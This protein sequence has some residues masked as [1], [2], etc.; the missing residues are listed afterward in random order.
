MKKQ[1]IDT[2]SLKSQ[3]GF[4]LFMAL[5]ALVAMS[6]T[7]MALMRSVD[8]GNVIAGNVA[9]K[10]TSSQV[11]DVGLES[12]F[13]YLTTTLTVADLSTNQPTGCTTNCNYYAIKQAVDLHDMPSAIA[14]SGVAPVDTS[15]MPSING[16]YTIK[17]VVERLC[18]VATVSDPSTECYLTPLPD[19]CRGVSASSSPICSST[20]GT[21]YRATTFVTGP[22]NTMSYAQSTFIRY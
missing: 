17:Y 2:V 12:A 8:T 18:T 3:R 19:K 7:A 21:Y 4:S 13:T 14:W 10:Q 15:A 9:F 16:V 11:L 5:V 6:L 20:Q 22:R 1:F